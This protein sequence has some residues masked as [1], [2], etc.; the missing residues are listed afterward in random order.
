MPA[1][2]MTASLGFAGRALFPCEMLLE[3]LIQLQAWKSPKAPK[4]QKS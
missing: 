1:T 3:A 4:A 2:E